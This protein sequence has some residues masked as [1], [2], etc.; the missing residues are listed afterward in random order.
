MAGAIGGISCTLVKGA[1]GPLRLRS[2]TWQVPGLHGYGVLL[3]G[4]GDGEATVR[5][6]LLSSGAGV[7]AWAAN[8]YALQ[9]QIVTIV[10]ETG[11]VYTSCLVKKV[12]PVVKTTAYIP[13]SAV[14]T[15]GEIQIEVLR[16]G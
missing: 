9:G 10:D 13:G 12:H 5:A 6:I 4:G 2:E 3:L 11:S 16:V 8:L 7:N 15:R 1:V 14:T